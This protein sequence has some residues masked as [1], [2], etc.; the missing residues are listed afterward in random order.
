MHIQV[1][2]GGTEYG[3]YGTRIQKKITKAFFP[4]I[5][6]ALKPVADADLGM[7]KQE[8]DRDGECSWLAD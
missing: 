7:R 1:E 5:H 8:V 3:R 4:R 6:A 2:L